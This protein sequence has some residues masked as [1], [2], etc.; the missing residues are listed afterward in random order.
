MFAFDFQFPLTQPS[1]GASDGIAR[2]G[3]RRD[4]RM[5]PMDMDI[6]L[7]EHIAGEKRRE[8]VGQVMGGCLS[9]GYLSLAVRR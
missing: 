7:D 4:A 2:Q 1:I 9:V 6:H 5:S 3:M 8:P